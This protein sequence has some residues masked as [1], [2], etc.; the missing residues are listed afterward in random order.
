[1]NELGQFRPC[2]LKLAYC[3]LVLLLALS[4]AVA[5]GSDRG[6]A[7][8]VEITYWTGWSGHELAVQKEIIAAFEQSHPNIRVNVMS[9]AGSYE[10]VTISFAAGN[11]PDLM[12]SV[13]LDDLAAYAARGA[14]QPLDPFLQRSGR[15]VDD[16]YLPALAQGLRYCGRV[17]GLM[18]TVNAQFVVANSRLLREAGLDP[19]HPIETTQELDVAN[20]RLAKFDV[21]GNLVRFGWRPNDLVL[22]GHVFGGQWYD[23]ATGKVTADDPRNVEAL[24]YLASY[25]QKYGAGRLLAYENALSG[26]NLGYVSDIGNFAGLF[27]GHAGM[28][29]TGEWC[30]EFIRRYAPKDF[31]FTVFAIPAPPN[32]RKNAI[33]VNGSVFVIPRDAKHPDEAWELLNYLTSPDAVKWFC[34]G[35]KN[36]PPLRR[37]LEDPAFRS[38]PI[39]RFSADLLKNSNALAPPPMP[40]WSYYVSEINRAQQAAF[41]RGVDP[42]Q[43]L[44]EV[45]QNVEQRLRDALRY[46]EIK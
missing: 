43:A 38:S 1:M 22:M 3:L 27:G 9:V 28:L 13:W 32:G 7:R 8:S 19:N 45:R 31:E 37:L 36:M 15:N 14:L 5:R 25:A 29:L 41:V 20:E 35:I 34:S 10:K 44:L 26:T 12:S 11:P 16:E 21:G 2:R 17:W 46:A 30:E 4:G 40:V 24:G 39:M 33:R 42:K 23:T 18:V 6:S